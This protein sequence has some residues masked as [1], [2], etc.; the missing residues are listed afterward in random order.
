MNASVFVPWCH[1]VEAEDV[2]ISKKKKKK[3][4]GRKE[5]QPLPSKSLYSKLI[6]C[7]KTVVDIYILH[8]FFFF[9]FIF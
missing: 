3:E 7:A 9:F 8:V 2:E 4:E 5:M 1:I 6:S